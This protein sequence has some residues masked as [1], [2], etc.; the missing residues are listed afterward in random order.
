MSVNQSY[1]IYSS[2]LSRFSCKGWVRQHLARC[3]WVAYDQY[4]RGRDVHG[5]RER[6]V[7]WVSLTTHGLHIQ[8]FNWH[9]ADVCGS[10]KWSSWIWP[11]KLW[12]STLRRIKD[13][14]SAWSFATMGASSTNGAR[15]VRQKLK[16]MAA[17]AW[18][19]F[20]WQSS[21]IP[22]FTTKTQSAVGC[23]SEMYQKENRGCQN[24]KCIRKRTGAA[25]LYKQESRQIHK[26]SCIHTYQRRRT[27]TTWSATALDDNTCNLTR[28]GGNLLLPWT[29]SSP[30]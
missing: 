28:K 10:T 18:K 17:S 14:A 15:W 4:I 3:C 12:I 16:N 26:H 24:L 2:L 7:E 6:V 5:H 19:S 23:E 27:A 29:G 20:K 13:S 1:N 21:H 9:L 8:K 22:G 25:T 11:R 30:G